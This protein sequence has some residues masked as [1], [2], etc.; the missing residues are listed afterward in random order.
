[1]KDEI[2]ELVRGK[3]Y[4]TDENLKISSISFSDAIFEKTQ[5]LL[6]GFSQTDERREGIVYWVGEKTEKESIIKDVWVPR[7]QTTS[8]SF[9]VSSFENA[10]IV[11][12]LLSKGWEIIAQVSSRPIGSDVSIS[13]QDE[14][15]GFLP[16]QSMISII[17]RD[18]GLE[19]LKPLSE[20][21][22][23]YVFKDTNFIRLS[24]AQIE[25]FFHSY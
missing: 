17:V 20:K 6:L 9:R 13:L 11:A 7:A 18:Y 15:I 23:V 19:G 1:M 16:F 25:K 2:I 12:Q 21:T 5:D 8:T 22:G 24:S 3:Q 10:A 14:E 4:L